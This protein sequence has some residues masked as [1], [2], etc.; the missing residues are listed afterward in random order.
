M[1]VPVLKLASYTREGFISQDLRCC[2]AA[3]PLAYLK[4][5]VLFIRD[6]PG[7]VLS[8]PPIPYSHP[9]VG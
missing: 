2:G 5:A 9:S 4:R 3:V 1:E 7:G 8:H 6:L